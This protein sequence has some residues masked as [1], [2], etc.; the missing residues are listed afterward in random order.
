MWLLQTACQISKHVAA[1]FPQK[2]LIVVELMW[3]CL[4]ISERI[5]LGEISLSKTPGFVFREGEN[6]LECVRKNICNVLD[7]CCMVFFLGKLLHFW[8]H[9]KKDAGCAAWP[10]CSHDLIW[11]RAPWSP[12]SFE[13]N[14]L[15]FLLDCRHKWNCVIFKKEYRMND[16][17]VTSQGNLIRVQIHL[18]PQF[19]CREICHELDQKW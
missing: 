11:K 3:R 6:A 4:I 7:D 17:I 2:H 5:F 8:T 18:S 9:S 19:L 10:N 16:L 1:Q 12:F 15:M 14:P 13:T